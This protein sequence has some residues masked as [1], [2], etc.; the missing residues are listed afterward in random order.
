[1]APDSS[2][3]VALKTAGD[4]SKGFLRPGLPLSANIGF[5]EELP[6]FLMAED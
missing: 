4:T 1:M 6:G 2:T 5:E 3:F